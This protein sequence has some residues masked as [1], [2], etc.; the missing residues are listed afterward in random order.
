MKSKWLSILSNI[1][2]QR[3]ERVPK[4]WRRIEEIAKDLHRSKSHMNRFLRS[5]LEQGLVET[6]KFYIRVDG[7]SPSVKPITHYKIKK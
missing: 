7:P 6:K 4:D 5:A 3:A 1:I 2:N